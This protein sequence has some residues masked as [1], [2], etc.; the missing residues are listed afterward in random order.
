MQNF[1]SLKGVKSF[2]FSRESYKIKIN[3]T[4]KILENESLIKVYFHRQQGLIHGQQKEIAYLNDKTEDI[5][6]KAEINL[7]TCGLI[8]DQMQQKCFICR[9]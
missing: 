8:T 1:K 5:C 9:R 3:A 6:Y 7:E 4:M 2:L